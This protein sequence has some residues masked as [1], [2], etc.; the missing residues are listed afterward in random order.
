MDTQIFQHWLAQLSHLSSAPSRGPV[1]NALWMGRPSKMRLKAACR[2]Y[3]YAR[4]VRH[5]PRSWLCGVGAEDCGVIA[6]APAI[7]PAIP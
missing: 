3:R 2:I 5:R 6:V 4:T 7:A 1:S